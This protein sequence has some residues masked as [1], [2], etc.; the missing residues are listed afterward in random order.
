MPDVDKVGQVSI[1]HRCQVTREPSSSL[2]RR[3]TPEGSRISARRHHIEDLS[4]PELGP[5]VARLAPFEQ[6][7]QPSLLR[8]ER[9][10]RSQRH[11]REPMRST[12]ERLGPGRE[13]EGAHRSG[14][15]EAPCAAFAV[16]DALDVREHFGRSVE[17]I[18]GDEPRRCQ[19]RADILPNELEHAVVV[20]I[21]DDSATSLGDGAQHRGLT[22][23]ARAFEQDRR[24]LVE[25]IVDERF[26][27]PLHVFDR[28]DHADHPSR[29]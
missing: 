1:G 25:Q 17:L 21:E 27:P 24:L 22:G 6:L 4:A 3:G 23:P 7:S 11:Q 15:Q 19:R 9:L 13:Q 26:C 28:G 12:S 8:T 14:E 5:E 20:E 2:G 18:D 16:D 29:S 10:G